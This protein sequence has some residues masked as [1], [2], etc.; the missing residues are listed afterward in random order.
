MSGIEVLIAII[1]VGVVVVLLGR[2]FYEDYLLKEA[3]R[4][5]RLDRGESPVLPID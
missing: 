4:R 3:W 1:F 2:H 5:Q